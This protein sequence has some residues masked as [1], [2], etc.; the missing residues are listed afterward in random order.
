MSI[1]NRYKLKEINFSCSSHSTEDVEKVKKAIV[2]LLPETI[3]DK[4]EISDVKLR[5]HAGNEISLLELNI[6]QNKMISNILGYLA[7]NILEIDKDSL[8]QEVDERI[9]EN[10]CFYLRFNKQDAYN[11]VITLDDG[12]N[13]IRVVIKFIVYKQEPNLLTEALQNIGIIKK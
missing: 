7:S 2:N 4:V 10:N 13:S 1:D 12:D 5:G 9:D 11:E 8:L 3:R 6:T